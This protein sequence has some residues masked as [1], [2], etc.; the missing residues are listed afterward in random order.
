MLFILVSIPPTL[1]SFNLFSMPL[2]VS[3]GDSKMCPYFSIYPLFLPLALYPA[4]YTVQHQFHDA[5]LSRRGGSHLSE[6]FL[7]SCIIFTCKGLFAVVQ[8]WSFGYSA[9]FLLRPNP[10]AFL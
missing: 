4:E 1:L 8:P 3:Q 9:H 2:L 6:I 5:Q 7:H 10:G